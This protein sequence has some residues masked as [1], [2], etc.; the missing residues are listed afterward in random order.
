MTTR[1]DR[2]HHRFIVEED[3][4][5]A[6]LVYDDSQPG[7][8]VLIHTGVPDSLGGRGIGGALVQAA[9]DRAKAE[10]LVIVP[11]CPFAR[12]WLEEHPA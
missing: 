6:E 5:V 7:R 2:E 12:R 1:D 3:G 9:V 11:Q 4:E 10:G 8:L